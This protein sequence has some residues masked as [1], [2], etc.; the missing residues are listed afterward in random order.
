MTKM[1]MSWLGIQATTFRFS[2][3]TTSWSLITASRT[4]MT[5]ERLVMAAMLQQL[6]VMI[7]KMRTLARIATSSRRRKKT[8]SMRKMMRASNVNYD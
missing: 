3:S 5:N 2:S 8:R 7:P 6:V 4:S 1:K